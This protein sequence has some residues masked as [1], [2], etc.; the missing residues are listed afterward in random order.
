MGKY[1]NYIW[2]KI[3]CTSTMSTIFV[4]SYKYCVLVGWFDEYSLFDHDMF[5]NIMLV[6]ILSWQ[7]NK[8]I[9]QFE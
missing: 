8:T 7:A 5:P 2:I 3:L 4:F 6:S 9:I 1:S